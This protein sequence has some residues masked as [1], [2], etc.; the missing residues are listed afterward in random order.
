M[1]EPRFV[2]PLPR[3]PTNSPKDFA[4]LR[5]LRTNVLD[6]WPDE[7]FENDVFEQSFFGRKLILLN[8]PE[9]I[10]HVLI[11]NDANYRR[12]PMRVRI[13]RPAVGEGLLLSEGEMW[14]RQRRTAAPAFTPRAATVMVP[15]FTAGT[16]EAV[17]RLAQA[18]DRP[19][20]LFE[21]VNQWSLEIAGR[22]M[23]SL[24]MSENIERMK[25]TI[26][27]YVPRL[28]QPYLLDVLLPA[29]IRSPHD[30]LRKRFERAWM[31]LLDELIDARIAAGVQSGKNDLFNMLYSARD[32]ETNEGFNRS[33]LRDQIATM[34][35]AGHE[36]TSVGMFWALFLLASTP[37]IQDRVAAEVEDVDLGRDAEPEILQTLV[38]TR[39]V[40]SEALRIYP[41]AFMIVRESIAADECEGIRIPPRSSV[42]VAPWVLHRMRRYWA[43]PDVFDPS[44]FLPGAPPTPRF[45]Y[46]PFGIGPRVCIGAQFATILATIVV[47]SLVKA[48]R[49]ELTNSKAVLPHCVATTRPEGSPEFRLL[50]RAATRSSPGRSANRH[51]NVS[52]PA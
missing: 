17:A 36:T 51:R 31:G 15:H 45:G 21:L 13:L 52:I 29:W 12:S 26:G 32:P 2:P 46:L 4:L 25:Q 35:V 41:P 8:S 20:R 28:S 43:D 7:A 34:I 18:G 22:S 1:A 3:R 47:A 11:E 6:L 23:F 5:A 24:P 42:L 39:A 50:P 9:A 40:V 16:C 37:E 44:R 27:H 19:V 49:I 14:R 30:I 10:R 48:F 33:Q 38:Y